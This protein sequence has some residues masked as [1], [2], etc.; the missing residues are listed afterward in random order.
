MAREIKNSQILVYL[1]TLSVLAVFK[2][3]FHIL[4]EV[5][6]LHI[7]S[8]NNENKSIFYFENF[9]RFSFGDFMQKCTNLAIYK[10]A[11]NNASNSIIIKLKY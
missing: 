10:I 7:T 11:Q 1:T 5:S 8:M 9:S 3:F 6:Y 2:H 4:S